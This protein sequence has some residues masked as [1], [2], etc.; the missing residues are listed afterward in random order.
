MWKV[1][2]IVLLLFVVWCAVAFLL[3]RS[4]PSLWEW[5]KRNRKRKPVFLIVFLVAYLSISPAIA[6]D[7]V[8]VKE[9]TAAPYTGLLVKEAR[10]TKMLEAELEVENLSGRLKIQ[11]KLTL[12]LET[13]YNKKLE[14]AVSPPKFYETPTFNRWLGFFL[15]VAVTAAAIWG[16][17]ELGKA[18]R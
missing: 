2:V 13:M 18:V 5:A 9:G 10:F 17:S 12:N 7:V 14:E 8:P 3:S 15:G 16:V 1:V 6:E 11:E 4:L